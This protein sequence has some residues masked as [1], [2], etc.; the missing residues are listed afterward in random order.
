MN[1]TFILLLC[2]TCQLSMYSTL[3]PVEK[4]ATTKSMPSNFTE[5]LDWIGAIWSYT[6]YDFE[7]YTFSRYTVLDNPEIIEGKIYYPLVLFN[8]SIYEEGKELGKWRIRQEGKRV[9]VLK[10][11]YSFE[12]SNIPQLKEFDNDYLLYDFG[13][14]LGDE[15]AELKGQSER[16]VVAYD[17]IYKSAN[18][19]I[20]EW[21]LLGGV[22]HG[23]LW[24]D[25]WGWLDGIG[26][27]EDLLTPFNSGS[28]NCVCGSILNYYRSADGTVEYINPSDDIYTGYK[29]DD[30][31]VS[32]NQ[33]I[34]I[35][36][37]KAV[38]LQINGS[39]LLC[40]SSTAVKLEVYTMDAI[41]VGESTF[42][43]GEAIV[44]VNK[45]P[46]T[47][48]YIVTYPDGRRESG[49]VMVK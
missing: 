37:N 48:L 3:H 38:N 4:T 34:K 29:S 31:V 27:M 46:A 2:I 17:S 10:E 47:Y 28:V 33:L 19:Q 7:S 14:N 6:N 39:T 32:S 41:K 8:E 42:A 9:Y 35:K 20:F 5:N 1:R 36:S 49:K 21:H 30:E 12:R 22:E 16:V 11:D 26:G 23:F 13:L 24:G 43:N 18:G 45:T 44:K 15:Y 40:T 25:D